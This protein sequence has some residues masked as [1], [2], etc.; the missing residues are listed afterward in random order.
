MWHGRIGFTLEM[1]PNLAGPAVKGGHFTLDGA[2]D[3]ATPG[4]AHWA[5]VTDPGL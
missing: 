2:L 1:V 5:T 4:R 3:C